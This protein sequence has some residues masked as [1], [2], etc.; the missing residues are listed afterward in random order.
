MRNFVQIAIDYATDAINDK[1]RKTHCKLIRQAAKRFLDDLKRADKKN[2][3]FFFDEWH[4]NDA[5]DFIE[6]LPHV[7]GKWDCPT[8]IMHPSH[9]FFVV[10]LFGF[11]KK[12][13]LNI[14]EW[15]DDGKFYPRRYSAAL[16]AVAR[17]NAKSTL[18]SAIANY[19]GGR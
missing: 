16:F 9:V 11:R 15:G 4:A 10:Q 5:C 17:K 13:A 6:K 3:P 2:C 7:E 19:C 14:K 12:E 18:S 1:K 8:I